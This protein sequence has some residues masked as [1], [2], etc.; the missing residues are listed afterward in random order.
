MGHK[1]ILRLL[2]GTVLPPEV[3]KTLQTILPEYQIHFYS[4]KPDHKRSIKRRIDSLHDAFMFILDAYPPNSALGLKAT[5][6][7][8]RAESCR[9]A[10]NLNKDHLVD[11]HGELENYV[12]ALIKILLIAWEWKGAN[13][14]KQAVACLN[15]AEQYVLMCKGRPNIA[16]CT[17]IDHEGEK[18][19]ILQ[20]DENLPPY[21]GEFLEEVEAV[22]L[23]N[24]P[25]T[26]DV[27]RNLEQFQ[28]AYILNLKSN[29]V[30]KEQV[31][32]DLDQFIKILEA[33]IG[34]E[35]KQLIQGKLEKIKNEDLSIPDWYLDLKPAY[36]EALKEMP[37]TNPASVIQSVKQ[38]RHMMS[39]SFSDEEFNKVF[40]PI[41]INSKIPDWY[42]VLSPLQQVFLTHVLKNTNSIQ[43]VFTF[44]SSR[45]RLPVPSNFRRHNVYLIDKEGNI[46]L[47]SV[48]RYASSHIANREGLHDLKSVQKRHSDS[49]LAKVMSY[50]NPDQICLLQ[51][52]ISPVYLLDYVP[53][54]LIEYLPELPPDLD[55]YK[56]ARGSVMRSQRNIVQEGHPLNVVKYLY[57]T[58]PSDPDCMALLNAGSEELNRKIKKLSEQ[59][60]HRVV[61]NK[62]VLSFDELKQL[63]AGKQEIEEFKEI[64]SLKELVDD[65]SST[66][67]SPM[68]SASVW[69]YVGRE[70]FLASLEHLII[71]ALNGYSYG[72]CVSGKDRKGVEIIHTDSEI[73]FIELYG[74][75]LKFGAP[76]DKEDRERFVELFTILFRSRH[77]Q[78]M[79]GTNAPGSEG[80]KHLFW[81]L[82]VDIAENI[83][84]SLGNPNALEEEDKL[85]TA[86]EVGKIC[87]LSKIK[88]DKADLVAFELGVDKG[89]QLYD[90]LTLLVKATP[91]VFLCKDG[92]F[93]NKSR[94]WIPLFKKTEWIPQGID[95]INKVME[96]EYGDNITRLA[97]IFRIVMERPAIDKTRTE[98]TNCVYNG[99]RKLFAAD[100]SDFS[101]VAE[102]VIQ[103]LTKLFDKIK[104]DN[105]QRRLVLT[106]S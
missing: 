104:Q 38:F 74:E 55:L 78:E 33:H 3:S 47:D 56:L 21:Y 23:G 50:A 91:N 49:N 61:V 58:K 99:I 27:F 82:P 59:V 44:L 93:F 48:K 81:Y 14:A 22:K 80:L 68:G 7:K 51:T 35:D 1:T 11:L 65:Y 88:P 16:T 92:G 32:Q 90:I 5:S 31:I 73:L 10:C 105:E 24:Y 97:K 69:D 100:K 64:S 28:Q 29:S 72:S 95:D 52:L 13:K 67:E 71:E 66:L 40:V 30:S 36:Q 79:A 46:L 20:N 43:E 62:E 75:L 37:T 106:L 87:K 96:E 34:G 101:V 77:Q 54:I 103:E 39:M 86:N 76:P 15:E 25:L 84:N 53:K 41:F 94:D 2:E 12:K 18:K 26:S 19:Y 45:H 70:L 57:Y 8:E 102:E 17:L 83:K 85:A 63:V 6:F 60:Q 9:Q 4:D 42:W 89:Y 98:A